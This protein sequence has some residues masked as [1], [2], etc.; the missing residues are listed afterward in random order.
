MDLSVAQNHAA[1]RETVENAWLTGAEAVDACL[2]PQG[3]QRA[4]LHEVEPARTG[5]MQVLS[6]FAFGLIARLRTPGPIIWCMTHEQI[7]ECGQPYAYGL[8]AYGIWPAQVMITRVAKEAHLHFA[9]E[10]ALK[11]P[12]VGAVLA[13]GRRPSFTG[14]R[15]LSLLAREHDTPCLIVCPFGDGET[16]S[17]ALSRWQVAP[18][19]GVEDPRDPF[20]PGMPAWRV[21]LARMR[22]GQPMP[23]FHEATHGGQSAHYPWSL[24][25]DEQTLSFRPAAAFSR[26]AVSAPPAADAAG[27]AQHTQADRPRRTM[28]G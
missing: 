27:D 18:V 3:L 26:R 21:A 15:R 22:A 1:T 23:G 4:G 10:E 2:P 7:G 5:T 8:Q 19:A 17:A 11:T 25:W 13:E 14:S 12:G 6:G 9:M 16:G 20:G 24:V 28:V